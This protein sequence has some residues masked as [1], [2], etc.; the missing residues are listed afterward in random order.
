MLPGCLQGSAELWVPPA[1]HAGGRGPAATGHQLGRSHVAC[2]WLHKFYPHTSVE[3]PLRSWHR[4]C[5]C[6]GERL[7]TPPYTLCSGKGGL[8]VGK[9]PPRHP[10]KFSKHLSSLAWPWQHPCTGLKTSN[11]RRPPAHHNHRCSAT[12]TQLWPGMSLGNRTKLGVGVEG[13][14]WLKFLPKKSPEDPMSTLETSG[15]HREGTS[16]WTM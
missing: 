9:Y 6:D 11:G 15:P 12:S 14:H 16:W 10:R 4:G 5:H 3:N 2:P 13:Y 1:E 7:Q 8:W